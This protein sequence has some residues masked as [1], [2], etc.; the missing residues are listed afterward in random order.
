MLNNYKLI[1]LSFIIKLLTNK[2]QNKIYTKLILF[3]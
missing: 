2:F 3:F 1:F